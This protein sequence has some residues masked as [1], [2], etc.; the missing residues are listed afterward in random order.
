MGLL[1]S[2]IPN[3]P[4]TL[5]FAAH[6]LAFSQTN[7]IPKWSNSPNSPIRNQTNRDQMNMC[8][9][10]PPVFLGVWLYLHTWII[11]INKLYK[12]SWQFAQEPRV[13]AFLSS[14]AQ[15]QKEK[16]WIPELF[17]HKH[18]CR[19]NI[20]QHPYLRMAIAT[21]HVPLYQPSHNIISNRQASMS[22]CRPWWNCRIAYDGLW[23]ARTVQRCRPSAVLAAGNPIITKGT[24][25]KR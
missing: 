3:D 7:P 5:S 6:Q 15:E 1:L 13:D 8:Q 11:N 18:R 23:A 12:C 17:E 24:K 2:L 19:A 20:C 22:P 14:L 21:L 16:N 9:H 25:S 10:V 4:Q